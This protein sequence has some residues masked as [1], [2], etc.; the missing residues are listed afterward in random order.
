MRRDR[1]QRY[2]KAGGDCK[3]IALAVP[4]NAIRIKCLAPFGRSSLEFMKRPTV[5][6]QFA[7]VCV[8]GSRNG[9]HPT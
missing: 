3:P 8:A 4:A 1:L 2:V 6:V 7:V 9:P 5:R